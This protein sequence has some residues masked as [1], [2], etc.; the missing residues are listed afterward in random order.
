ML[1]EMHQPKP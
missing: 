1:D